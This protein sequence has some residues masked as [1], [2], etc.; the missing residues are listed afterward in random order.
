MPGVRGAA[1]SS[2]I[3]FGNGNYTTTPIATTGPS[4]LPPGYRGADRLARR[5][6]GLLPDDEAFPLLRGR[7][8]VDADA[9]R[10]RRWS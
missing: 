1:V 8:F 4:P 7:E 6:P 2:G 9:R 10:P 3:P 5:Q